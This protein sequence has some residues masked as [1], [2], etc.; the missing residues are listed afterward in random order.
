MGKG[1]DSPSSFW[2]HW[3]TGN[4]RGVREEAVWRL[5]LCFKAKSPH[6]DAVL[7]GHHPLQLPP[8][9]L[10]STSRMSLPVHSILLWH[11]QKPQTPFHEAPQLTYPKSS[12]QRR[13]QLAGPAAAGLRDSSQQLSPT[14]STRRLLVGWEGHQELIP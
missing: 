5:S 14:A 13:G 3:G 12:P 7:L 8:G 6:R 11:W 4:C 10:G 9:S 2:W 1:W